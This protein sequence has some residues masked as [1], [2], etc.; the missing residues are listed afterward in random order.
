MTEIPLGFQ[1]PDPETM[2]RIRAF[3]ERHE[4]FEISARQD[5]MRFAAVI[6]SCR[7]WYD[8]SASAPQNGCVIHFRPMIASDGR[9]IG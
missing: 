8:G 4:A 2:A 1:P 3:A 7:R 9:Y 5:Q 6:C